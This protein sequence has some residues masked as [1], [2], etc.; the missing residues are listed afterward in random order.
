MEQVSTQYWEKRSEEEIKWK[1]RGG[2]KEMKRGM[3]K[4]NKKEMRR[5]K[6]TEKT[7]KKRKS[8]KVRRENG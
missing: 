3:M 6:Q 2:N 8:N 5:N 7:E 1:K 4:G